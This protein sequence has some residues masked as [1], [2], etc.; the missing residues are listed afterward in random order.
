MAREE[1]RC[2]RGVFTTG[3]WPR[4]SSPFTEPERDRRCKMRT[5]QCQPLYRFGGITVIRYRCCHLQVHFRLNL[6]CNRAF[7]NENRS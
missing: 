2:S 7:M 3:L 1:R 4:L 6:A 5:T